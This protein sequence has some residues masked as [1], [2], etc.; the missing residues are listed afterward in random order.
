MTDLLTRRPTGARPAGA[1]RRPLA[2]GAALAG[3]VAAGSVLLGCMAVALAGWFASDAASYGDTRDAIRVGAD[4]WLLAHGSHLQLSGAGITLV[5]LG[6]TLVCVYVAFRLGRWAA[7]TSAEEGAGTV[8]FGAIVL[9][10]VY[11]VATVLTAVLASDVVAE[12]NLGLAFCGGFAVAFLGGGAG[13]AAGSRSGSSW[14][15]RLPERV[16]AVLLGAS[17]CVLLLAA[18]SAVA[19][20]VALLLHLGSAATV[21]SQLHVDTAGGLLYTVV[22]A[23]VT[24]NAVLLTGS[25]LLG[26]GFAVG[27]GSLVSST[28]VFLG[29]V[30]AFPLLAALPRSGPAPWWAALLTGVPVLCAAVAAFAMVRRYPRP[31]YD[32][33]AVRGLCAGLGGGLLLAALVALA[34]GSV[35]PGRMRDVGALW[36]DTLV[37]ALVTMAVGG[38]L[39]GLLG[40]WRAR[41]RWCRADLPPG[42]ETS[43]G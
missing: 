42:G 33:G 40:T 39:G 23:A 19:L 9:A 34:G 17:A 43:A 28:S 3:A 35:G 12:P 7:L 36:P 26:P 21:L 18:A 24:P 30:P 38:L 8:L 37:A 14:W 5:P 25:Y 6:L 31:A 4:A 16:R 2:I 22:V 11:G 41:R 10:G 13:I 20:A 27:T 15:T 29:P 32:S 1:P